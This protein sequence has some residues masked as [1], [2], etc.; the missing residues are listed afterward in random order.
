MRQSVDP[1]E[2]GEAST[3]VGGS[4]RVRVWNR[5]LAL[6]PDVEGHE[7]HLLLPDFE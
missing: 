4:W 7:K 1:A 5:R 6:K 3:D 2:A